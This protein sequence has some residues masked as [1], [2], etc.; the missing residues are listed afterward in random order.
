M[1][2]FDQSTTL[3]S[4]HPITSSVDEPKRQSIQTTKTS[5]EQTIPKQQK[6]HGW[7][8][9]EKTTKQ[10]A[11]TKPWYATTRYASTRNATTRWYATT[12]RNATK[13]NATW[14]TTTTN[15]TSWTSCQ[16]PA[17]S[18]QAPP[19]RSRKEPIPQ[20]ASWSPYLR[21]RPRNHRC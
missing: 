16:L 13:T 9:D 5:P 3:D 20:G 12:T 14:T 1:E 21:L 11:T 15:A 10:H 17:T 8:L 2:R 6:Q 4:N 18:I 7:K 19:S